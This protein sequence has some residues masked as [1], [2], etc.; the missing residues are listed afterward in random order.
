MS[1]YVAIYTKSMRDKTVAELRLQ[2]A[3]LAYSASVTAQEDTVVID[4]CRAEI[5]ALTDIV[6]DNLSMIAY[7]TNK[8]QGL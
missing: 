6:L 1:D 4:R 5:H 8:I 2:S 7:C 3:L